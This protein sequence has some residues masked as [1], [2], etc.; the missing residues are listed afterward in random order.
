MICFSLIGLAAGAYESYTTIDLG[1]GMTQ[2]QGYNSDTNT[3]STVQSVPLGGGM[4]QYNGF[5]SKGNGL[6]GQSYDLGSG[7]KQYNFSTY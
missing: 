2:T 3:F 5:D 4:T 6:S 1:G 7:M